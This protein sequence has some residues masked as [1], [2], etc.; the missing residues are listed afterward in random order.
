MAAEA[1]SP[2]HLKQP[3]AATLDRM[4]HDL[5]SDDARQAEQAIR[6]L[7]TCRAAVPF[8]QARLRLPPE[9]SPEQLRGLLGALDHQQF[10]VRAQA[11]N[12]LSQ[13]LPRMEADLRRAAQ[14]YSSLEVRRRLQLLLKKADGHTL[15]PEHLQIVRALEVM[16][17]IGNEEVREL[18]QRHAREAPTSWL[19]QEAKAA[20]ER[21]A[22]RP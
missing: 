8:L 7:T 13:L 5:A 3:T 4:W 19:G 14:E 12:E 18:F 2:M 22:R 21:L 6:G 16:E 15:S 17:M 1:S 11:S 20:L 10:A 9:V